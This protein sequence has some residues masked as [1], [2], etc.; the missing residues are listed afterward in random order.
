MRRLHR[1]QDIHNFLH[2]QNKDGRNNTKS[3]N[4][5]T[6]IDALEVLLNQPSPRSQLSVT[7]VLE[8]STE[9]LNK[10]IE[11]VGFHRKKTVFL[12]QVAQILHDRHGGDIP[13]TVEELVKLPGIGPKMAYLAVQAAWGTCVI[14][15]VSLYTSYNIKNGLFEL[16]YKAGCLL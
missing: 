13:Q 9:A 3:V 10:C 8:A 11:K 1:L 2:H 12:K 6:G 7:S 15:Q 14:S 4:G 16:P 5:S